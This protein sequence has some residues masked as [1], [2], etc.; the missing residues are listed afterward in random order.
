MSQDKELKIADGMK[1][2]VRTILSLREK[3]PD[4]FRKRISESE[5]KKG[6]IDPDDGNYDLNEVQEKKAQ[7]NN[8]KLRKLMETSEEGT[9][10]MWN[11][12]VY[13]IG[14]RMYG[15]ESGSISDEM[16]KYKWSQ[17]VNPKEVVM[18]LARKVGLEQIADPNEFE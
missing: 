1:D 17:G 9:F 18:Q 13:D 3:N 15:M 2:S 8:E 11:G 5:H 7:D 14:K 4:I 10:D 6:V 12:E 16:L